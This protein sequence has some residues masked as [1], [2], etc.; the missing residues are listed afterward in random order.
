MHTNSSATLLE[1]S[2]E[3]Q[4][5]PLTPSKLTHT[6]GCHL[7]AGPGS[8][9]YDARDRNIQVLLRATKITLKHVPTGM[10]SLQE[11][12][13]HGHLLPL[14]ITCNFT[15]SSLVTQTKVIMFIKELQATHMQ[16]FLQAHFTAFKREGEKATAIKHTYQDGSST[17]RASQPNPAG[18]GKCKGQVGRKMGEKRSWETAK[19]SKGGAEKVKQGWWEG[20]G[21]TQV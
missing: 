2:R 4:H 7:Q 13:D 11:V 21:Q 9:G 3:N 19:L 20:M 6:S 14:P 16:L 17:A 18:A 8:Q 10:S 12:P 1:P 15:A 5:W